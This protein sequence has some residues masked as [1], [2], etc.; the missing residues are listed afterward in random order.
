MSVKT[1]P[2]PCS[3]RQL[4]YVES[5]AD[6]TL[7]GGAAGS[8][9]SEIGVID[10]LKYIDTP[11]FIGVMT[12][13]TTPQ[14]TGPGGLLSKCRRVFS[15]ACSPEEY[16]WR[17]K[18]GKFVFHKSGAEIYLKHFERDD[19]DDN[20][21]GAEANLF[22]IDEGTQFTQHMVQ[23]IMSR[24]RNPSCPSIKPH[25]KIT[26]NPDADHFLRKWV[27]PYLQEDGTPDRSK[28]GLIRYFTFMD[29]D[30]AWGDTPEDLVRE[31]GVSVED[32]LSFTFISATV[33]D[34]PI[35]SKHNPKYVSWLKGLKGVERARLLDG[36][37]YVREES[38]SYFSRKWVEE[39]QHVNED[40]VWYTVRG[41]DFAGELVSDLNPSPDYTTSVRMRKMKN[42]DYIIDD[43]RRARVRHG[44]W[45]NF[46][47][48]CYQDDPFGVEYIIPQDPGPAAKRATQLFCRRLA[49]LG[50]NTK[51]EMS[52]KS[53]VDRFRPFASVA[54]N[55]GVKILSNCGIDKENKITNSNDFY[56]EELEKFNGERSGGSKHGRKDDLVDATSTA[57]TALAS[58]TVSLSGIN[59]SLG[60]LNKSMAVGNPFSGI[61]G[62]SW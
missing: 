11:G 15:Q 33:A 35:V 8:G 30:F 60:E 58:K 36:N 57:F 18:D 39:V 47:L 52:N 28:D 31:Y 25:L 37:W 3:E 44:Q 10:F 29:G 6:V 55:G 27:E 40:D 34:N 45:E 22:Y 62:R 50:I 13:R 38:S 42:G 46:V 23:Y 41:F 12:R 43:I 56:Y 20:W 32:C 9:K 54:E 17:A 61:P 7:Y 49:E 5:K 21:Q 1:L 2:G 4:M 53:K 26:C 14:M 59:K 16:T 19:S 48:E 24:M 51:K